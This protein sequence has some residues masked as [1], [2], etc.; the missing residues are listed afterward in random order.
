MPLDKRNET[1]GEMFDNIA[2]TYDSLNHILSFNNDKKW[3]RKAIKKLLQH[4]PSQILDVATGSGD[5]I[6][7]I[8]KHGKMAITAI[9]ISANML[10]IACQKISHTYPDWEIN[11]IQASAESIPLDTSTFDGA[12]VAFGVRNFEDLPKGLT[13]IHRVLKTNG[14]LVILEFVKPQRKIIRTFLKWYL[15]N[16]LPCIGKI[17][18]KNKF[19]YT[20][21]TQSIETF[22]TTPEFEKLCNDNQFKHIETVS[23]FYGL[24]AI[25]VLKK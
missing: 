11:F 6:L 10:T 12:C 21:L 3:R 2:P 24:V 17:I 9:D 7:E 23:L 14:T 5:M 4:N 22:Y 1:M 20:Y 8:A 13:E 25:F 19:A 18:S 16:V 15:N